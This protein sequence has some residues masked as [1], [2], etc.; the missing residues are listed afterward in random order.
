MAAAV[1]W[2]YIQWKCI[3][4]GEVCLQGDQSALWST[5]VITN[6]RS[7]ELLLQRN[8]A[9]STEF[10]W[11]PPH[12]ETSVQEN[13]AIH[14]RFIIFTKLATPVQSATSGTVIF[15]NATLAEPICA[16][17]WRKWLYPQGNCKIIESSLSCWILHWTYMAPKILWECE[18][19]RTQS[20]CKGMY[21]DAIR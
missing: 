15:L 21:K 20:M 4:N 8:P 11:C 6:C 1:T 2:G 9:A 17:W 14:T 19:A 10:L 3:H 12:H 5:V 16:C 7:K 18:G 13:H